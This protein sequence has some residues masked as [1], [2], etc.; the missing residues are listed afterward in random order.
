MFLQ[1]RWVTID[2]VAYQL[3]IS[4]GSAFE[5]IRN[6]LACLFTI[7]PKAT[8][9]IAQRGMFGYVQMTFRSQWC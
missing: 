7:G 8:R 2:E 4:H 9:R 3:P 5:I 6:R 1:N